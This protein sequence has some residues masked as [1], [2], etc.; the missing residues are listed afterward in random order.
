MLSTIRWL[1]WD[2]LIIDF[3]LECI[4]PMFGLQHIRKSWLSSYYVWT[5]TIRWLS[6]CTHDLADGESGTHFWCWAC[7]R[8]LRKEWP[9]WLHSLG[10]NEWVNIYMNRMYKN[11]LGSIITYKPYNTGTWWVCCIIYCF[12]YLCYA[13][14]IMI[15]I[16]SIYHIIYGQVDNKTN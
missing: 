7:F 14:S 8:R 13:T 12:D 16:S 3:C 5:R 1:F 6:W 11:G 9:P 15:V 4:Y 10:N 2:L